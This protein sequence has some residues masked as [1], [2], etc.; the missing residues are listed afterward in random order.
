MVPTS[1]SLRRTRRNMC[2]WSVRW[3]W[4]VS[5]RFNETSL[6]LRNIGYYRKRLK[7]LFDSQVRFVSSWPPSWRAFM[8]SSPRDWSPSLQSRSWSCSSPACPPSTSTTSR[9]IQNTTNI[10]PA[11]S[12]YMHSYIVYYRVSAHSFYKW[13]VIEGYQNPFTKFLWLFYVQI[14][15]KCIK[16]LLEFKL[17]H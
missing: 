3:R 2:I 17:F 5:V 9:P 6:L 13:F 12:R 10:S 8:R 7:V 4:R 14:R 15:K 16:S 1:S 11:L